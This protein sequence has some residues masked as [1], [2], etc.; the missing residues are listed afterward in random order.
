[1]NASVNAG[2]ISSIPVS[3]GSPGEEMTTSP[4]FLP[5][6]FRGQR[7]LSGYSPCSCKRLRQDFETKQQHIN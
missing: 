1:M 7:S 6:K 4:V 3:G 2:D 5:M